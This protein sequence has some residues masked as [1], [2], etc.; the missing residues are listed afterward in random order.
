MITFLVIVIALAGI[1]A[2]GYLVIKKVHPAASIFTVGIVLMMIAAAMGKIDNATREI[3][4]TGNAFYDELQIVESIF[5][6]RFTGIGMAIM[7]LFGF[8]SYMRYIGA[9]AKAVVIL[10][11]PLRALHG[12]YWLIPVG[13]ILGNILS[14]VVPSAASLSLLLIA[15]LLPA[16]VASGLTPL[17][18]GA[19]VVTSS[20]IVPTPLEAGLIQGA[21]LVGMPVTQYV[22][23][24]VALATIPTLLITAFIHM[25]W[26]RRCDLVD[27]RKRA[28]AA[29][30]IV[31]ATG[32]TGAEMKAAKKG[33]K[34]ASG[35]SNSASEATIQD[36]L[37]RAANLPWFYAL[38]PLLPL[39]LI[40]IS[41]ALKRLGVIPFEAGILPVTVVSLFIAMIVEAIRLRSLNK[42]IDAGKNFFTGMGEAAG[43]VVAL[44]V[45]AAILVEGITQLGVIKMLTD[46]TEGSSGAAALIIL[47]FVVSVALLSTLTGSGTAP[48]F[49]FSEVVPHL[50]ESGGVLP[51]RMLN[52]MWAT[53]NLMRQVSPVCAAVLIVSGA[54]KVN[55]IELV[56]RTAV[57]MIAA[58]VLNVI[59]S[60]LFIHA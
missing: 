37:K 42:A 1:A 9:D 33:E 55:P 34:S 57:P 23:G 22:F 44:L 35:A 11:K 48:Y 17:T 49:A 20:T 52:S 7:V 38:L 60:F 6:N 21:D 15:T 50:A 47:I 2:V 40:I 43:G 25:W 39:L 5:A 8:V 16:L 26:Q 10:S 53:S 14:L 51:I 24:H 46:A 13:F 4:A 58:T 56:K 54:I 59:F 28:D 3:E 32:A 41:A 31:A 18:V 45:A 12:S 27:A 30:G 29:A 19:I 36:A